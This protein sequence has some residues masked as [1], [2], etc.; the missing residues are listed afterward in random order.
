MC[1]PGATVRPSGSLRLPPELS[2]M[3]TPAD[4]VRFAASGISAMRLFKL[5]ATYSARCEPSLPLGQSS[6]SALEQLA[7]N[8]TPVGPITRAAGSVRDGNPEPITVMDSMEGMCA[9]ETSKL[10]RRT[11]PVRTTLPL[12]A[13]VPFSTFVTKS[14]ATGLPSSTFMSHGPLIDDPKNV[15]TGLPSLFNTIK[16]PAC[17]VAAVPSV[18]GKLPTITHPVR[19]TTSAVV[20]PT[21]PVHVPGR[22]L[23]SICANGL[24]LPSGAMSTIVVPVPCRLEA[25]LKLLTRMCPAVR[26]PTLL[27]TSNTPY[28]F[29]SPLVGTVDASV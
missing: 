21:P 29:T 16:H 20:N 1:P 12:A 5:Y 25:A 19:K 6:S 28:G 23:A 7:L 14:F 13:T 15:S 18:V 27:F 9:S 2:V 8:A 3:P 17:A 26:L 4:V 10:M 11:V 24:M 22:V